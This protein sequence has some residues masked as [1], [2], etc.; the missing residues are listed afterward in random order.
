MQSTKRNKSIKGHLLRKPAT[1]MSSAARLVLAEKRLA[2][3]GVYTAKG[4]LKP[5]YK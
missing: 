5:R 2:S 3:S 4:E 1:D